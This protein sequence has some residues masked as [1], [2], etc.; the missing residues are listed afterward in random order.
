MD[1]LAEQAKID[2]FDFRIMHLEDSRAI[3]VLDKLKK[4]VATLPK[5]KNTGL[6]IAFSRYKNS[7]AYI[8]VAAQ[9]ALHPETFKI[10]ITKLWAVVDAGEIISLD[11][12][13]NQIEGGM[14]QAASWTLYEQVG[15]EQQTVQSRNWAT[16]PIIRF[17]DVPEVDVEIISRPNEKLQGVGEI[18]MC[19]TPGAIVNAI[20]RAC[21]QRIRNLPVGRQLEL[22][23]L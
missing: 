14:I 12:V 8:A 21:G 18:A 1:E 5:E 7:A 23:N 3:E 16:Y 13:I 15:F 4:K 11:S 19:V 22:K 2:P 6:G 10:T 20:A 9:V 17:S